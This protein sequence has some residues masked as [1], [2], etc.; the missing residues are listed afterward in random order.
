NF[1]LGKSDLDRAF[2]TG[3][4]AG[5]PVATLREIV[6]RLKKTYCRTIGVEYMHGEDPAIKRWLQQAMEASGNELPL[7]AEKK[8]RILEKLTEAEVL[9]TFLHKKYIGAKR[10]SL[11]GSEALIPLLDRLIEDAAGSGVEEIVIGM[12]H[13]GR[14]NVLV[15]V[16]G[17]HEA[18]LFAEF[19][20][21][22]VEP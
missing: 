18:E 17:K 6:E 11:E 3:D 22:D 7:S 13:R 21:K 1:N 5:P 10:F 19:E 8:E 4:L 15:N 16:L 9:E 2:A 14:L 12:A 20:D